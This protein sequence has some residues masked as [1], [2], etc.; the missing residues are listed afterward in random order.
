MGNFRVGWRVGRRVVSG[1]MGA[2]RSVVKDVDVVSTKW[3][4]QDPAGGVR[5]EM[6]VSQSGTVIMTG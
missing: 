5:V 2:M 1:M 3:R 4:L 6:E